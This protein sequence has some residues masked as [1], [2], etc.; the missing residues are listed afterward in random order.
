MKQEQD[1]GLNR[2]TNEGITFNVGYGEGIYYISANEG[3]LY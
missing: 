1:W 2:P 3:V